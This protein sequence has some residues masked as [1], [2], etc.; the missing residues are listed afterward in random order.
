MLTK[1]SVLAALKTVKYPGFSRDIVSF[2]L[3]REVDLQPGGK[4]VLNLS[5]STAD[6]E[7]PR[8]LRSEIEAAFRTVEGLL[9][10]E[11]NIAIQA[12]KATPPAPGAGAGAKTR[13]PGVAHAIAVASGKGGV[14]KSTFSVNLACALE[15]LLAEKGRPAAVGLMD[16]DIHGPSVPLMMGVGSA[17]EITDNSI[18]PLVNYGVQI[19]SM[20]LLVD[21]ETP[22][23]WRGPM[24]TKTIMQFAQNVSWTNVEILIIDLPPGTG[25]AHLT[26]VQNIALDGAV[27]VTTPQTAAVQVARR[28]AQL[29]SKVNVPILGVAENMSFLLDANGIKLA[30]FGSGGGA[31]T[32]QALGTKLLGQVPLDQ[33]VREGGDHGVPIVI[34]SP[35]SPAAR[36]FFEIA[37]QL[38]VQ[39]GL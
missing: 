1:D 22:I 19:M 5:V 12:P 23:V 10:A 4:V 20:G 9:E 39:I 15:K 34:G 18:A 38:L 8:K 16:C 30:I 36:V 13:I 32:A 24:V 14:G 2:G 37:R 26:L 17:P 35:N 6:A 7:V 27:V 31:E 33:A 29:F 28:G 21:S 3:V 11:V 25:D